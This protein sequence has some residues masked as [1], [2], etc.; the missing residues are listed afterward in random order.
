ML[1]V[2]T[3]QLMNG[4]WSATVILTS[5]AHPV[6]MTMT[7]QPPLPPISFSRSFPTSSPGNENRTTASIHNYSWPIMKQLATYNIVKDH[8]ECNGTTVLRMIVSGTAGTGKSYLIHWLSLLL[9]HKV[10]V[11][12]PTG[13]GALRSMSMVT[14]FTPSSACQLRES[15]KTFKESIWTRYSNH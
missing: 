2:D 9:Q 15:S 4:C 6:M 11:V 1:P 3:E 7:G 13:V 14:L 12:A 10:R 5:P 8:K